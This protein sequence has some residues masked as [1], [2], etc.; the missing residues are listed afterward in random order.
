MKSKAPRN[1]VAR[2]EKTSFRAISIVT[3]WG[4]VCPAAAQI[5]GK[6]F[7]CNEV[8]PLPLTACNQKIC[9][10]VYQHHADRREESRRDSDVGIGTRAF[11]GV[12]RRTKR[13]R[14]VTDR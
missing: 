9:K 1:P 8:P 7:L 14:R 5:E 11:V 3:K 2:D 4:A 12:D 13:G 10:C 6:R